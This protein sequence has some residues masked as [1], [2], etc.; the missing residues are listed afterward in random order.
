MGKWIV[1]V[2]ALAATLPLT[3]PAYSQN[4]KPVPMSAGDTGALA[5]LFQNPSQEV[6]SELHTPVIEAPDVAEKGKP[7]TVMVT[8]GKNTPHP[9]TTEHHISYV[10][11]FFLPQGEKF[12]TQLGKFEFDSHGASVTGP[13]TSTVYTEPTVQLTFK[14]EKPGTIYAYS[15]CNWHG[16]WQS[17]KA[18]DVK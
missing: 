15:Y 17:A 3:G 4:P 2:L 18:I 10:E 11:V 6:L 1:A 8:V 16:L 5:D 12:P 13:N 14:T 9:N 7:V